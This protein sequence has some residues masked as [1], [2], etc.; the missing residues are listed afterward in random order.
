MANEDASR[1]ERWRR[2]DSRAFTELVNHWQQPLARFFARL[3]G[4]PAPVHDLCQEVFLRVYQAAGQYR[5]KGNFAAW[6]Y[7]IALNIG[8]DAQRRGRHQPGTL[9]EAEPTDPEGA[10]ETL[11]QRRELHHLVMEAVAALPETLRAVLALRHDAGL[12]FEEIARL[13]G[14]PASTLKSRFTAALGRLRDHL[15]AHGYGPEEDVA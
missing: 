7:R 6:L 9:T 5:E 12:N 10:P 2:G 13:T 1:M 4:R 15:R 14:I 8:R 3:L 11:C